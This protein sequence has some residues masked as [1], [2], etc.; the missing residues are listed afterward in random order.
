L[1]AGAPVV[2]LRNEAGG[3]IL[4]YLVDLTDW[5][6]QRARNPK[7]TQRRP[8]AADQHPL[9]HVAANGEAADHDI[10]ARSHE[11]TRREIED[12]DRLGRGRIIDF[13]DAHAGAVALAAQLHRIASAGQREPQGG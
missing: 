12:F 4:Q 11:A 5:I 3:T 1:A 7:T 10:S 9:W 6:R 13:H 2:V 8:N